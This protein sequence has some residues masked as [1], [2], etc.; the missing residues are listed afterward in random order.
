MAY[1]LEGMVNVVMD[2]R[3]GYLRGVEANTFWGS[4]GSQ[5]IQG[6]E[7]CLPPPIHRKEEHPQDL[8]GGSTSPSAAVRCGTCG[9]VILPDR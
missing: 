2:Q 3:A 4:Q 9:S 1:N 8:L 5:G 7:G 6:S